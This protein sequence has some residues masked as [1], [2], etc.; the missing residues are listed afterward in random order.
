MGAQLLLELPV[1]VDL[2][3]ESQNTMTLTAEERLVG[4]G[5]DVQNAQSRMRE[6]DARR[7]I[8]AVAFATSMCDRVDHTPPEPLVLGVAQAMS[9]V[10]K[11]QNTTHAVIPTKEAVVCLEML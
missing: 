2:T 7:P 4:G 10:D 8:D 6:R 3:I 11:P 5:V 1:V 9:L